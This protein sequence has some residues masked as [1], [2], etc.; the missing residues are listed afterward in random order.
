MSKDLKEVIQDNEH[1]FVEEAQKKPPNLKP[2]EFRAGGSINIVNKQ[3]KDV[4]AIKNQ[5]IMIKL[6]EKT[7][8]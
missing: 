5:K 1:K 6:Q 4:I 7:M 3:V 2:L 8:P